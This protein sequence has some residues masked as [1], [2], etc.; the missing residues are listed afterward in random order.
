VPIEQEVRL[1]ARLDGVEPY[2]RWIDEL[3]DLSTRDRIEERIARIRAGNFGDSRSVGGGV[4]ELRIPIAG[5]IR[6]YFGRHDG[7][8]VILLC[9]GDKRTQTRDIRRAQLYWQDYRTRP[10]GR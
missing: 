1:Y 3:R 8:I 2:S 5:G 7:T 4:H 6:I 10:H 9:G